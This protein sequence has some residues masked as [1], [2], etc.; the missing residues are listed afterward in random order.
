MAGLGTG[1]VART[2]GA[3]LHG[4]PR[5]SVEGWTDTT[6]D[7]DGRDA[8]RDGRV[9]GDRAPR[10][11][12]ALRAA[13]PARRRPQTVPGLR[14]GVAAGAGD[15]AGAGDQAALPGDPSATGV[16]AA[17]IRRPRA[18]A[19]TRV[20]PPITRVELRAHH[21]RRAAHRTR[22]RAG[23]PAR[24]TGEGVTR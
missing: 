8:A 11:D 21:A 16:R 12:A 19:S 13:R 20:A 2:G 7:P 24:G 3:G 4:H 14:G 18:D 15:R 9:A 23:P 10:A 5:A 6:G 22:S 17:Q 1:A